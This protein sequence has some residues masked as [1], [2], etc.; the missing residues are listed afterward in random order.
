MLTRI[1]IFFPKSPIQALLF[2]VLTSISIHSSIKSK[3]LKTI[4]SHMSELCSQHEAINL[5]QGFPDFDVQP[6]LVEILK[7]VNRNNNHQYA[8]AQGTIELRQAISE[9]TLKQ[10]QA[11]ISTDNFLV[12]VGA[13]EGLYATFLA[14][15]EQGDEVIVFDPCYDSYIPAIMKAGGVPVRIPLLAPD[16]SYDWEQ[17][18]LKVTTKTKFVVINNPHNPLGKVLSN[19]DFAQLK[20]FVL[21]N[22][23]TLISD[24]V[25]EYIS[26][27]KHYSVIEDEELRNHS[28]VLSSFGKTLHLT[29]WKIGY[30]YAPDA[31]FR[32]ILDVH[33]FLVFSV[34]KPSQLA[35][36]TYLKLKNFDVSPEKLFLNKKEL[37]EQYLQ[38]SRFK[39]YPCE[40]TYFLILDYR[41]ISDMNDFDFCEDLI[42]NKGIG[43]IPISVFY[44]QPPEQHIIRLCFAKK[45]E[46]LIKAME[47][48]CKI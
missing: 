16:F 9:L 47:V 8:P 3:H 19:N 14:L 6:Q 15:I 44:E 25:Y 46:T 34:H 32:K 13:T 10:Y 30:L 39:V 40:G 37:I 35:I 29:G 43:A 20:E 31:L 18:K 11:D 12:T 28:V 21:K 7:D 36:A 27:S 1:Y 2:L 22:K 23:L 38:D 41:A 4:F 45:D 24:E 33:Q 42:I 48:I 5:A 26:F 17:I